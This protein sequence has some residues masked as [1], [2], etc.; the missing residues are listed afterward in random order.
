MQ[1]IC[2]DNAYIKNAMINFDMKLKNPS[3]FFLLQRLQKTRRGMTCKK[4][5]KKNPSGSTCDIF[6][7][8]M[9][10]GV[11]NPSV[12]LK[13]KVMDEEVRT[14]NQGFSTHWLSEITDGTRGTY[15][16]C[17]RY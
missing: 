12:G 13:S 1:H 10:E 17:L 8:Q 14:E 9:G 5:R 2:C 16:N 3:Y 6:Y 11:N 15:G 4:Y 7:A